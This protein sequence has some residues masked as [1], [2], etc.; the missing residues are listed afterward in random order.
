MKLITQL[1]IIQSSCFESESKHYAEKKTLSCQFFWQRKLTLGT[2]ENVFS[3]PF[4]L[5]WLTWFFIW[6]KAIFPTQWAKAISPTQVNS[7]V[8]NKDEFKK[9]T[10]ALTSLFKGYL[11][12]EQV[13]SYLKSENALWDRHFYRSTIGSLCLFAV[14]HF[15]VLLHH[16]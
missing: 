14:L 13:H 7:H 5:I 8:G 9:V 15:A 11:W 3:F 4:L 1:S 10:H 16:K 6:V 12:C 2:W